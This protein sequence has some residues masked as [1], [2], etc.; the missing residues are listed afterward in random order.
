MGC[1]KILVVG[2][3]AGGLELATR[4]GR[5]L[6]K[7]KKAEIHLIDSS[8]THLWKPLLHE[9]AAGSLDTGT[10]ALSYRAQAHNHHFQF[11]LGRMQQLDQANKRITLEP[12]LDEEGRTILGQR[13]L[14]YDYLVLAVGSQTN[15]FNTLGARD[16]CYFLDSTDQAERF[17][18]HLLN[19]FLHANSQ[20]AP[21][22]G[23]RL[24]IGIVGG[25]A[26]GV[27]LAAELYQASEQLA[28][29][30]LTN[31]SPESIKVVLIEASDRILPH[32]PERISTSAK[33]ELSRLG[34]EVKTHTRIAEVLSAG[35]LTAEEEFI[36]C[37]MMVW[38]AG[39]K[40][41]KFLSEIGLPTNRI[42]QVEV[43]QSL[44]VQGQERIFA[45]GDCAACPQ[46]DGR[47]VP[48]RAQAAHQQASTLFKSL[49]RL[50]NNAE[51]QPLPFVYHDHGSL[52]SLSRYSALGNLMGNLSS[53]SMTVE[54]K[55]AR[56]MY[57]SLYRM[58][59]R[60]LHG[61]W[62]TLLITLSERMHR[63]VKPRLKLH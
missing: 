31:L 6:G 11:H 47:F 59:L 32:L 34:V 54:G 9:I 36:R 23:P 4:L 17:H 51:E 63:S 40:A 25:G 21:E 1:P 18:Q 29:F 60:A 41:P 10:H 24:T 48:P 15:D 56:L 57:I 7:S 22:S 3:G 44:R 35:F 5:S 30:G 52:V 20:Q 39:V 13:S 16:Y 26:T 49:K 2:G 37:D 62:R 45:L 38:A 58:H 33:D 50:I 55:L 53:G 46:P 8:N 28:A 14:E 27:E 61:F 12:L 19:R 43:D 42:Q